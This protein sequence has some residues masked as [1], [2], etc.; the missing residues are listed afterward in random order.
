MLLAN[1]LVLNPAIELTGLANV[2]LLVV[3]LE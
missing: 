2:R 1:R 3:F